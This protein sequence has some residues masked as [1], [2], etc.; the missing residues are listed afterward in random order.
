MNGYNNFNSNNQQNNNNLTMAQLLE[1]N[2]PQQQQ[3]QQPVT[4]AEPPNKKKKWWTLILLIVLLI[5][6][7]TV[8]FLFLNPKQE[9][10]NVKENE[11]VDSLEWSGIYKNGSDYVKIYQLD[12]DT[13]YFDIIT[14]DSRAYTTATIKDNK[15]EAKIYATYTLELND[16]KLKVTSTDEYMLNATYTK[17]GEYTKEDIYKDNYGDPAVLNTNVNGTFY[18]EKRKATVTIY[19]IDSDTAYFNIANEDENYEFEVNVVDGKVEHIEELND[20]T[21]TIEIE[22]TEDKLKLKIQSTDRKRFFNRLDGTYKK[23]GSIT[24]DDLLNERLK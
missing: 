12:E 5:V 22:F 23:T 9:K 2:Q 6:G 20:E 11:K 16:N 19:Q 1:T 21:I 3:Q 18:Y 24:I 17:K 8:L 7:G 10:Q 15:A 14:E 4:V 13:I